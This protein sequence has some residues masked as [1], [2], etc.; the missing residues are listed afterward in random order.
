MRVPIVD[1]PDRGRRVQQRIYADRPQ[2]VAVVGDPRIGK[3]SF[4]RRLVESAEAG[5]PSPPP[6]ARFVELALREGEAGSSP[7]A[8][9]RL[10]VERAAAAEDTAGPPRESAAPDAAD[11]A[12]RAYGRF[13]RLVESVARDGGRLIL[14]LDDFDK[15]TGSAAFP[16]Q[17]FSFL[18]SLANNF[19]VAYVTTSRLDLQRLCALKE[20]EES[21]FFN[22]FQN[23]SLG[24]M[25]EPQ[26]REM[27]AARAPA[28][29]GAVGDWA[30][31]ESGG[32]P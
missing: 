2:C 1:R 16:I 24:P 9:L 32:L 25:D 13:Q 20:V 23:V 22:I 26:V 31:E 28:D 29:A 3:S 10:A 17:F 8:F 5:D 19:P 27:V 6:G 15:V 7:E 11:D 21:P 12:Q 30:V 4:L 14:L 18:R